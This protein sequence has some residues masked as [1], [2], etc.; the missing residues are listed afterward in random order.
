MTRAQMKRAAMALLKFANTRNQRDLEQPGVN[1]VEV[2]DRNRRACWVAIHHE[3][4]YGGEC[5]RLE[6]SMLLSE[7][8]RPDFEVRR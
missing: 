6:S 7:A 8:H 1:L 2:Y 5:A 3:D 4:C